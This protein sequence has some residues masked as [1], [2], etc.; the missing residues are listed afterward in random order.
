MSERA[1]HAARVQKRRHAFEHQ[2]ERKRG[3]EIR[4]M[5]EHERA[6]DAGLRACAR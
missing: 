5:G 3:E 6:V 1:L 4:Q 2:E